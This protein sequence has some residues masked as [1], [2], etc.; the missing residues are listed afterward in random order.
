MSA[1]TLEE[2]VALRASSAA[3]IVEVDE[4]MAKL[5]VFELGGDRF[6][7]RGECVREILAELPVFFVPGCP[8]QIEGVINLRGSVES[9]LR[10]DEALGLAP[11]KGEDARAMLLIEA[12]GI[13][14]A[15]RIGRVID[16]CDVP[17]RA[18]EAPP[19][20]LAEALQGVV[21]GIVGAADGPALLLDPALLL[22]RHGAGAER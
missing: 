7:L 3:Q 16:V 15:I 6:A 2:V 18:I 22:T 8:A 14:S 10:I 13:R 1:P 12:A 9:V 19:G 4:P 17:V 11:E 20:A 21:C 5:V